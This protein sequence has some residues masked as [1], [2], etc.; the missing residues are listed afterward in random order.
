MLRN[1]NVISLVL[2]NFHGKI[3][4][5]NHKIANINFPRME[6]CDVIR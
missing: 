1:E 4:I 2:Y 6:V 3:D 5:F